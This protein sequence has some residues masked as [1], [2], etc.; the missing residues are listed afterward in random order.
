M[1]QMICHFKM[2]YIKITIPVLIYQKFP[3]R[4]R[5]FCKVENVEPKDFDYSDDEIHE[6]LKAAAKKSY[7]DFKALKKR[8]YELRHNLK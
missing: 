2:D 1:N 7:K 8:E 4:I 5:G 3:K 6:E